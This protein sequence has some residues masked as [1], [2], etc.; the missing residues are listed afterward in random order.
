MIKHFEVL[1][2]H[3]IRREQKQPSCLFPYQSTYNLPRPHYIHRMT[4]EAKQKLLKSVR[5]TCEK[6]K[7]AL[8]LSRKDARSELSSLKK[9]LSADVMKKHEK[10]IE[11]KMEDYIKKVD[12]LYN[13]KEKELK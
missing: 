10:E 8:R 12:N 7:V 11:S 13:I 1:E 2:C 3:L 4:G 5:E 9:R 6:S